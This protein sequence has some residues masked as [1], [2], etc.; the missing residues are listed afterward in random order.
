VGEQPSHDGKSTPQIVA[1]GDSDW[2]T[3]IPLFEPT[4]EVRVR[5]PPLV[6]QSFIF[7]RND[8][9]LA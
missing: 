4:V 7:I 9:S 8:R 5:E 6:V 3:K 2:V 1:K